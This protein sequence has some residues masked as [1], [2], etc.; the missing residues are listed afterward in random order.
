MRGAAWEEGGAPITSGRELETYTMSGLSNYPPGVTDAHPYFNPPEE[1]ECECGEDV[2][3]GE[4][5]EHCGAA[6]PTEAERREDAEIER[7]ER[8]MDEARLDDREVW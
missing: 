1:V 6:A 8:M 7:A 3:P 2:Y 5:C 4:V